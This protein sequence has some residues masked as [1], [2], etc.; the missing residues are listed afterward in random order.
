M[1][2]RLATAFALALAFAATASP[3]LARQNV[4]PAA[5]NPDLAPSNATRLETPVIAPRR[6][7]VAAQAGDTPRVVT[8]RSSVQDRRAAVE[9]R[10]TRAPVVV[11]PEVR[12]DTPASMPTAHPPAE[13]RAP[14]RFDRTYRTPANN[15]FQRSLE[16]AHRVEVQQFSPEAQRARLEEIN[17]FL[18]GERS[19]APPTTAAGGGNRVE[20]R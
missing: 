10:A 9:T 2:A 15:R 7:P 13:R 3:S 1:S 14:S 17:R 4:D 12:R 18:S 16:Q 8:P 19:E 11:T 6:A 20:Q 5:R